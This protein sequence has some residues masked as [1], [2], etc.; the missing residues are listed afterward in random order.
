MVPLP[1]ILC[2]RL[3]GP[4]QGSDPTLGS[5]PKPLLSFVLTPVYEPCLGEVTVRYDKSFV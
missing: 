3:L 2:Y 4:E 1:L 5:T